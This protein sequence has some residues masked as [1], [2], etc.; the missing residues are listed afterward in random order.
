[1]RAVDKMRKPSNSRHSGPTI[2]GA[3]EGAVVVTCTEN[4]A[5]VFPFRIAEDCEGKHV[6][7]GGAPVQLSVTVPVNP[8]IGVTSRL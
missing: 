5:A 8:L 2:G 4:G 7:S 6:E 1:M 3:R